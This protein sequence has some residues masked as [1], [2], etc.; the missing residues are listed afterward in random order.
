M[1][2]NLAEESDLMSLIENNADTI[3]P[4]VRTIVE[5]ASLRQ[6]TGG[7]DLTTT[8]PAQL[9]Q[10]AAMPAWSGA[11]PN[12]APGAFPMY[13]QRGS[14]PQRLWWFLPSGRLV[15]GYDESNA[16]TSVTITFA[17]RI[18]ITPEQLYS[19]G[20]NLAMQQKRALTWSQATM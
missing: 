19:R 6:R 15:S 20:Y 3:G 11:A 17:S 12:F 1:F 8:M 7:G 10:G 4:Q 9:P 13:Q 18:G 16:D 5:A 2:F 14:Y